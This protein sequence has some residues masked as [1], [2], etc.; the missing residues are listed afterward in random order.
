MYK[1]LKNHIGHEIEC[2]QYGD[3]ENISIECLCCNEVLIDIDKVDETEGMINSGE[4]TDGKTIIAS[5]CLKKDGGGNRKAGHKIKLGDKVEFKKA[6]TSSKWHADW[7][8][9]E[10]KKFAAENNITV[11]E[12]SRFAGGI[13]VRSKWKVKKFLNIQEGIICGVRTIDLNGSYGYED[14]YCFGD[15]KKVYLVAVNMTGFLRIPEEFIL[16]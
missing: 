8:A 11:I 7:D 10:T 1:K 14:G 15:H 4:I 6:L 9:E 5:L 13:R 12:D 3:G 16:N 2:V